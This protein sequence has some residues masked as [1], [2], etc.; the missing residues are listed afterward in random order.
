MLCSHYH[1]HTGFVVCLYFVFLNC[2]NHTYSLN[3]KM[4]HSTKTLLPHLHRL[5][6]FKVILA[7]GSPRRKELLNLMGI[8]QFDV[9]VSNFAENFD[10]QSFAQPQD[11][12]LKT[13]QQKVEDVCRLLGCQT[14]KYIV[15][16]ADT[17]VAIDGHVLEK[18][19]D[20]Q[21][22]HRMISMLSGKHHNVYT[23]VTI[24]SNAFGGSE[25]GRIVHT[26]SFVEST[27]VKF[28]ELTEDDVT[29]YVATKEGV[30]KAGSY[31]IQGLGGQMVEGVEG[32]Y[33]NVMGLP[34]HALSR[35]LAQLMS[36]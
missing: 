3:F 11:Y 32:C 24:F 26:T 10:I 15:I 7:S 1:Y 5:S 21:D 18:P 8:T 12:C 13:A 35:N 27:K 29:A 23:A 36:K 19:K 20:A 34:V 9:M 4:A 25:E 28:A 33:F 22:A 6:D 16:G 30:D 14:D 17:I 2:L 31:G